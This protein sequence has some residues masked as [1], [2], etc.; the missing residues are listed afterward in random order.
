MLFVAIKTGSI[1]ELGIILKS[2]FFTKE[3]IF[4]EYS[5]QKPHGLRRVAVDFSTNFLRNC[6]INAIHFLLHYASA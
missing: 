2:K 5:E 6:I 3:S 4:S 1:M